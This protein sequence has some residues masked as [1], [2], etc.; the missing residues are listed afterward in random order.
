MGLQLDGNT[1]L[2]FIKMQ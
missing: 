2:G 1:T